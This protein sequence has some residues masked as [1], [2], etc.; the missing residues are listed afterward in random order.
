VVWVVVPGLLLCFVLLRRERRL[1]RHFP[2]DLN[3]RYFAQLIA[4]GS[5]QHWRLV[6][7]PYALAVDAAREAALARQAR[8]LLGGEAALSLQP[9]LAYGA[10]AQAVA[11]KPAPIE[12]ELQAFAA[13]LSL[14]A[15]P[16]AETHGAFV[17]RLAQVAGK[18]ALVL[19]DAGAFA[20]RLGRGERLK[21]R[22]SLWREFLR[23]YG[24]KHVHL[25]DL[26]A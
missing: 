1:S 24:F 12:G 9:A 7:W 11:G 2:L 18:E 6:V 14:A 23:P 15:T 8:E 16:E 20:A 19:L 3:E 21:E 5:G 10:A 26:G 4:N 13:L 22:E 17:S 25:V